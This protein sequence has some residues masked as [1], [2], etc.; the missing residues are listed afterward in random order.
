MERVVHPLDERTSLTSSNGTNGKTSHA[1]A[2]H[3]E[4]PRTVRNPADL[5]VKVID[6]VTKAQSAAALARLPQEPLEWLVDR[7]L[8]RGYVSVIYGLRNIGKSRIVRRIVSDLSHQQ[9]MHCFIAVGEDHWN[10]TVLPELRRMEADLNNVSLWKDTDDIR[11]LPEQEDA[12]TLD[13]AKVCRDAGK[14]D[15]LIVLDGTI[16]AT[17]DGF[18]LNK[19]RDVRA[20]LDSV[21]RVSL[22]LKELFGITAS[23]ILLQHPKKVQKDDTA[24]VLSLL[25]G[26][27]MWASR[28]RSIIAVAKSEEN[29]DIRLVKQIKE[30]LYPDLPAHIFKVAKEKGPDGKYLPALVEHHSIT[31]D[32]IQAAQLQC[33]RKPKKM[34]GYKSLAIKLLKELEPSSGEGVYSKDLTYRWCQETGISRCEGPDPRP[35]PLR[36]AMKELKEEGKVSFTR[37]AAGFIVHALA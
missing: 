14:K 2:R 21:E 37:D 8:P 25:A 26:S 12:L 23:W 31:D 18:D 15:T 7:L 16:N 35:N 30:N 22:D 36:V 34:E 5:L 17:A 28:P 27:G 4:A 19:A 10:Q 13:V 9:D 33:D 24:D 1:H 3:E 29:P 6:H 32:E 20:F 11:R